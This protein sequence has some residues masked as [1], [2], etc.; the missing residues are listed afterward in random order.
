MRANFFLIVLLLATS[1]KADVSDRSNSDLS[2]QTVS[3]ETVPNQGKKSLAELSV[4]SGKI[5]FKDGNILAET[6]LV[7]VLVV[8]VIGLVLVIFSAYI[9][10]KIYLKQP[11]SGSTGQNIKLV[12]IKRLTPKLTLFVVRVNDK[13]FVIAQSGDNLLS[14]DSSM[15][16]A[17]AENENN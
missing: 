13:Q 14:L 1:V 17:S 12:E 5:P 10:K 8:T 15:V 6:S 7:R 3:Q 11:V 16:K 9:L 2:E 4:D